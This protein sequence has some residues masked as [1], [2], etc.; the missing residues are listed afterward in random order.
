MKT[1]P[2]ASSA[3]ILRP[4]GTATQL[5]RKWPAASAD[6]GTCA[7]PAISG[8]APGADAVTKLP[9]QGEG[10]SASGNGALEGH[11]TKAMAR[12]EQTPSVSMPALVDPDP[13]HT[14]K[15]KPRR[16]AAAPSRASPANLAEGVPA[17]VDISQECAEKGGGPH[18]SSLHATTAGAAAPEN[19]GTSGQLN[20]SAS[21]ADHSVPAEIASMDPTRSMDQLVD[22]ARHANSVAGQDSALAGPV[23]IACIKCEPLIRFRSFQ[24]PVF[25]DRS[26]GLVVLHWSR[27]IGK[28]FTLAAW[29]VDRLLTQLKTNS[30]WLITVLSNSRDNGAEFVLKCAEVCKSVGVLQR[31][32]ARDSGGIEE[33]GD[34]AV[35]IQDDQSPDL[36]FE[37]MRMEVR[38]R[39]VVDGREHVG[40]IKVLAANPRTARGF[41]GDLILD[42]FAFHE[43]SAAIWEAAEPILS[44]NPEFLCRIASTGNGKHNMFYRMA[45]GGQF[46][47]VRVS[48]SEA[49]RQGVKIYD[50]S[51]RAPITPDEARSKALDKRAYD[52]N[53]ELAFADENM[54]CLTHELISAAEREIQFDG[55]APVRIDEQA[56]SITTLERLRSIK[57]GLWIGNDV[58]RNR[59]ISVVTMLMQ[60]GTRKRVAGMLRMSGMRL[61][62]QQ[63][64]LALVCALKNFRAYEG[65]MT[66]IGLGLV[67][68]L[69]DEFGDHRIRGVNFGS[70]EPLTDRLRADGSK[71]ETAR[72]TEIMASELVACFEDR[73]IDIPVDDDL[74]D[75]LR[76]PEKIVSP[77]GRVSIA[78]TRDEAGHADH[79]WSLALAIRATAAGSGPF[80]YASV[81]KRPG[82]GSLNRRKGV[83]V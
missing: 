4:A 51:T 46:K 42:E 80:Y 61:P 17:R 26:T 65:D 1:R 6:S 55:G 12:S 28:S 22:A 74:R 36:R 71:R 7:G 40:R 14:S 53:Y 57:G 23:S 43:D 49:W 8:S 31:P 9:N 81:P 27:Q 76:K 72:V 63:R 37:N 21:I 15:R 10:E 34:A 16:G 64:Q 68:Y 58:G 48:R 59:D 62:E 29:S 77:G 41:S 33:I 79:F 78:A 75:D 2:K 54:A 50:P 13:R 44:A 73:S 39:I 52:Q 30:S 70:T 66:G 69:Q 38:I 24:Q 18:L 83:L 19:P 45:T 3:D 5:A 35:F 47:V 56:W 20:T 11:G 67:E 25:L 60:E 32:D 82:F